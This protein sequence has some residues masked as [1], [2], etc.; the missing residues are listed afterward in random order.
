MLFVIDWFG[1]GIVDPVKN[2]TASLSDA[3]SS[4]LIGS[5]SKLGRKLYDALT[6]PRKNVLWIKASSPVSIPATQ[7]LLSAEHLNRA[8][9]PLWLGFLRASHRGS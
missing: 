2:C 4:S 6:Q 1:K 8:G 7:P 3:R 9:H 5:K